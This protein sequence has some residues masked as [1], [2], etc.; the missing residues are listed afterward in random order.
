MTRRA[1]KSIGAFKVSDVFH[2]HEQAFQLLM[3]AVLSDDDSLASL[4]LELNKTLQIAPNL[5]TALANY[6]SHIMQDEKRAEVV[7]KNK[8][9]LRAFTQYLYDI[10]LSSIAYRQAT[11]SLLSGMGQADYAGC[12]NLIRDFYPYWARA[13]AL[14]LNE[15]N[16]RPDNTSQEKESFIIFWDNLSN[17]FVT[18]FEESLLA[19]Y[20][21]AIKKINVPEEQVILRVKLVK[22]IIVKQRGYDKTPEGYRENIKA[23]KNSLSNHDLLTYFL[24]V[25]RELYPIW[26][27]SQVNTA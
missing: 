5:I 12:L 15:K 2:S 8:A 3:Q 11:N 17:A 25:A 13:H 22:L 6:C 24:S 16:N 14:L 23:I 20:T 21:K 4:S 7:K 19:S 9:T 26:L 18:V 27:N 10:E 1:K